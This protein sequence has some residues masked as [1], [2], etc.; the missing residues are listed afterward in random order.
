MKPPAG[1]LPPPLV[2]TTP[3]ENSSR[4]PVL[5]SALVYPGLGQFMQSRILPGI[6]YTALSTLF[7]VLVCYFTVQYVR[8]AIEAWLGISDGTTA[9]PPS[10]RPL[11]LSA[12]A[13]LVVY[14]ANVYDVW[15]AH[16]R[17]RRAG[18]PG[19]AA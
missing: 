18:T 9:S 19:G 3:K 4:L 5:V 6:V 13:L 16:R 8:P 11:Q 1:S 10:L 12:G 15:L 7:T 17:K 2:V 14:L